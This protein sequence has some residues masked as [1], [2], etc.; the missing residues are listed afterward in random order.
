MDN[1]VKKITIRD[2]AQMAGVSIG[3]VDRVIHNRGEVSSKTKEKILKITKSL[4][5]QPDVLASA[6]ASKK[7][8]QFAVIMP[9]ADNESSFWKIPIIG[10]NKAVS[11]L[12]HFGIDISSYLFSISDK[13]SFLEQAYKALNN[14]PD[15]LII[16][17]AFKEEAL[18]II[19][20]CNG[21]QIPYAFFNSNIPNKEQICYIGQ[22]ARQSGIL[23][24]KLMD[25][26]IKENS[27][28]LI[29][30][31]LRFLKN[32]K[33]IQ[34]RKQGFLD[35]FKDKK[36]SNTQ[37]VNLELDSLDIGDVYSELRVTFQKNPAI[38]GIFVTNSRVFQVAR[39]LESE[40]IKNINLIGYDLT[41]ENIP[42]LEKG[43]INFLINQKPI[44]QAY[45]ALTAVFSKIVLKKEISKEILLP[46]DIVTKENLKYYEYY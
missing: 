11:E 8:S 26:G 41:E 9:A 30:S 38:N 44:E 36:T 7:N 22:D 40:K 25:Y 24:A 42:Y 14:K 29:V 5:Y 23:A 3:T 2:I 18:K 39:F 12:G 31:I 4:N 10:I 45:R 32:N 46:I 20:L 35:Y 28:I 19:Q 21:Q 27:Q 15:A 1:S 37:F 33:H 43:T 6:L 13:K 34:S 16:V 17:P